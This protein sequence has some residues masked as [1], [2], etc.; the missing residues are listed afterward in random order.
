MSLFT[1]YYS[2]LLKFLSKNEHKDIVFYYIMSNKKYICEPCNYSSDRLLNY[3]RHCNT[4]KH[5]NKID[6]NLLPPQNH[7]KPTVNSLQ[8]IIS[9]N[10]QGTELIN[11]NKHICEYCNQYFSRHDVLNKH[12]SL[13]SKK[14]ITKM[15]KEYKKKEEMLL[16]KIKEQQLLLDHKNEIL[17]GKN[18]IIEYTKTISE[19]V[20]DVL[21]DNLKDLRQTVKYERKFSKH[22]FLQHYLSNPP[23]LKQIEDYTILHKEY[24][25]ITAFCNDLIYYHSKGKIHSYL[26]D[27]LVSQYSKDNIKE[28]S[29]FSSD[30]SRHNFI[31]STKN[32]KKKKNE[33][34]ND[35]N[36]IY[37]SDIII[38]PLL[39]Y[40]YDIIL[41]YSQDIVKIVKAGV[42]NGAKS[43]NLAESMLLCEQIMGTIDD[44]SLKDDIKKH[45][46]PYFDLI[47]EK[48]LQ[49]IVDNS[50]LLN[51]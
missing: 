34:I 39:K 9:K 3:Q 25:T 29:L 37:V 5:N 21:K 6:S 24:K 12:M 42:K 23:D 4:I 17:G 20:K 47:K 31:C 30:T 41:E 44:K 45:I 22:Q 33:W 10:T 7:R 16:N 32:I 18:D 38:D 43:L 36:G 15:E 49:N 40:V 8:N 11:I 2:I 27:F 48:I 28:Q 1:Q 19:E 13:C 46:S 35:K 50:N 14:I 51:N 26:G